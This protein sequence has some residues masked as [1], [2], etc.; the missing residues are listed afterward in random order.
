MAKRFAVYKGLQK[1]L[2][3]RG[4]RG[5]YIYWGISSLLAGLV[6]GALTMTLVNIWLGVLVLAGSIAGGLLFIAGKQ[7]KG[8]HNKATATG[9]YIINQIN[10]YGRKKHI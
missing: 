1:P 6:L 5:K 2:V 10:H 8:L 3:F 7:R 9:I 4:F